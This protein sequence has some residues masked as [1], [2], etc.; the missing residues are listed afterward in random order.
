MMLQVGEKWVKSLAY[1]ERTQTLE[2]ICDPARVD[3]AILLRRFAPVTQSEF[4]A[5]KGL[6]SGNL[7]FALFRLNRAHKLVAFTLVPAEAA[8]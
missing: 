8:A 5:L 4:D 1:D 3:G 7:D 2:V 6:R